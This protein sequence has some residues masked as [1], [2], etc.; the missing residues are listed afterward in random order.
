M[1]EDLRKSI[2]ED[3]HDDVGQVLTALGL[4]LAFIENRLKQEPGNDLR[5]II[6]DSRMLAKEISRTVRSLMVELRPTQLDEY[7]LVSAIRSHAESFALRTGIVVE[8]LADSLF[9]RLS[10]KKEIAMFRVSQEALNNI[11]KHASATR[12][13]VSL[14]SGGGSLLLSI[15]DDGKGFVP[16]GAPQLAG[17]GW[18]LTN[19][20]QRAE[21]IGGSFR[22]HSIMGHGTTIEVEV[23]APDIAEPD[24]SDS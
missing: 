19:M 2:A 4:N 15:A 23:N 17:F 5:A 11:S 12:V 18:G 14:R 8:I 13:V 1:E 10:A 9:P 16:G 24:G 21:L 20:R 7:G 22:M 3:L 6:N